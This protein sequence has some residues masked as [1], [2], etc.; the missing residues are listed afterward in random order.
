MTTDTIILIEYESGKSEWRP[1][2]IETLSHIVGN[3]DR[4][5]GLRELEAGGG[6]FN[7]PSFDVART[8]LALSQARREIQQAKAQKLQAVKVLVGADECCE[9]CRVTS[10]NEN[11]RRVGGDDEQYHRQDC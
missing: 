2:T 10:E 5:A 9:A 4:I 3:F 11:R 8:A 1:S 7:Y 6:L